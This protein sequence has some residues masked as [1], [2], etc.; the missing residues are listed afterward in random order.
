MTREA[1]SGGHKICTSTTP[2]RRHRLAACSC[3]MRRRRHEALALESLG[4][5]RWTWAD[6]C[7]ICPHQRHSGSPRCS[8]CDAREL[9]AG[10]GAAQLS[11]SAGHTQATL[12]CNGLRN[13]LLATA[14]RP[15]RRRRRRGITC[16]GG[17][18]V[19]SAEAAA[20]VGLLTRFLG[21]G[22]GE[23]AT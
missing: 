1:E 5:C 21:V 8:G 17:C 12:A 4:R 19:A 20:R 11:R 16:G 9:R 23:T 15:S 22:E 14:R 18:G 2:A 7:D 3:P 13:R 10:G 6:K